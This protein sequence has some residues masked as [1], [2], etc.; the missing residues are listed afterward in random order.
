[1]CHLEI[2]IADICIEKMSAIHIG[3]EETLTKLAIIVIKDVMEKE[4][5]YRY[6]LTSDAF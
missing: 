4:V 2:C 3:E 1:M 5:V 6:K